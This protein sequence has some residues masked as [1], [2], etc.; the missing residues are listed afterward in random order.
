MDINLKLA[1]PKILFVESAVISTKQLIVSH[2]Y[3]CA[4]CSGP[5][6]AGSKIC[7]KYVYIKSIIENGF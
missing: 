3:K 5:H 1:G 7:K 2:L 6:K 4:N